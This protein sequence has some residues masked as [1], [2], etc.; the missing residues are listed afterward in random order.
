MYYIILVLLA[1]GAS[2]GSTGYRSGPNGFSAASPGGSGDGGSSAVG[3]F[4]FPD[5]FLSPLSSVLPRPEPRIAYYE[6][7]SDAAAVPVQSST[8]AVRF[9]GDEAG[10]DEGHDGSPRP[11]PG[12]RADSSTRLPLGCLL[13]TSPSPRD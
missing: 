7:S 12:V 1:H 11:S 2:T 5:P 8:A 3:I 4:L 10:E 9:E 13:Y 6:S